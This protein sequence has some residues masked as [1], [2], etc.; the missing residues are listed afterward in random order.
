MEKFYLVRS[1]DTYYSKTDVQGTVLQGKQDSIEGAKNIALQLATKNRKTYI[2]YEVMPIGK[3]E[4]S[5]A[6]WITDD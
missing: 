2:V 4:V 5:E 3:A 1:V 6:T